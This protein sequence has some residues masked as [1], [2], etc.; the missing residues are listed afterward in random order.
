MS[1][2]SQISFNAK[3]RNV[4]A[5]MPTKECRETFNL[6]DSVL[7][8]DQIFLNETNGRRLEIKRQGK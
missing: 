4:C 5:V 6:F 3:I 1:R 8:K 7:A 2:L